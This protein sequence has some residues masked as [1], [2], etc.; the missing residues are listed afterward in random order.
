MRLEKE[1]PARL[2]INE[3]LRT[4]KNKVGRPKTRWFMTI[5]KDL[6][7]LWQIDLKKKDETIK[8]LEDITKDRKQWQKSVRILMQ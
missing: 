3:H 5:K 6:Q 4:G 7:P 1:T 2:S 8:L